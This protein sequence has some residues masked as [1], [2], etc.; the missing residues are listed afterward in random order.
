MR[1]RLVES[2]FA[3]FAQKGLGASV[4]QDVITAAGVSQG[5][6]Y[7]YFRTN[8]DLLQAVGEELN[9]ELV[10]LIEGVVLQYDDPALRIAS[11]V[12]MYL[13][14]ARNYPLFAKFVV[15]AGLHLANPNNLIYDYL[16]PHLEAGFASGRFRRMP[17]EVALDL[18]GGLAL[19]AVSR[20]A[21]GE[22]SDDYPNQVVLALLGALGMTEQQ[23]QALTS[24]PL[25]EVQG[26]QESLVAR[27]S[28]RAEGAVD[29]A[30]AP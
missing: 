15:S 13:Q 19:I 25:M 29:A 10:N 22:A 24:L 21:A 26:S 23:A 9:N 16:P 30:S 17:I 28:M 5:T 14:K 20:I 27:A 18:I 2:A 3:V 6:F 1:A 4:I 8:E 11:G 7:N 12:R